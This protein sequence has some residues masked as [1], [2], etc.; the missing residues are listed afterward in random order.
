MALSRFVVTA[1][2]NL[3]PAGEDLAGWDLASARAEVQPE[4]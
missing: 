2:L 3:T 4:P 1:R